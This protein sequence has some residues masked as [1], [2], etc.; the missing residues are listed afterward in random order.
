GRATPLPR[1]TYKFLP[2]HLRQPGE[3]MQHVRIH[4]HWRK[5]VARGPLGARCL[6]N[7]SER[8]AAVRELIHDDRPEGSKATCSGTPST[9]VT[10]GSDGWGAA[11]AAVP[12]YRPAPDSGR[13]PPNDVSAMR[14]A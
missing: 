9:P 3:K 13:S 1:P 14:P 7:R 11:A 2:I 4:G 12:T 10:C 6:G 8:Q 5:G